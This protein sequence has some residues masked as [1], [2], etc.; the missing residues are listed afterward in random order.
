MGQRKRQPVLLTQAVMQRR[1]QERTDRA[2]RQEISALEAKRVGSGVLPATARWI[3]AEIERVRAGGGARLCEG[4]ANA[5]I[6]D[7]AV[8]DIE[9][10]RASRRVG[11]A[12]ERYLTAGGGA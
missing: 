4:E 10:A 11:A 3:D 6:R 7:L 8:A 5:F 2:R 1:A 9:V 12:W